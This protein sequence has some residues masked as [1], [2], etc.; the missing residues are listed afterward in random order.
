MKFP[1]M[2]VPNL[3][4]DPTVKTFDYKTM[5]DDNESEVD[6]EKEK[7]KQIVAAAFEK[8][9]NEATTVS[10]TVKQQT[11]DVL[12]VF[13]FDPGEL[14]EKE[15]KADATTKSIFQQGWTKYTVV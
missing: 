5:N 10:E 7:P 12:S 13:P 8:E 3:P 1:L 14:S 6:V 15:V 9:V 2:T 11:T 4:A